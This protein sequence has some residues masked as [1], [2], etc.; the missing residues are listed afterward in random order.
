MRN[1]MIAAGCVLSLA[2]CAVAANPT[3]RLHP[4]DAD[5]LKAARIQVSCRI[6][7]AN[8]FPDNPHYAFEISAAVP[9]GFTSLDA[10]FW[11]GNDQGLLTNTAWS[12]ADGKC[13]ATFAVGEQALKGAWFEVQLYV[14][15]KLQTAGWAASGRYILRLAEFVGE[16]GAAPADEVDSVRREPDLRGFEMTAPIDSDGGGPALT[17]A[18]R[19][20][21]A[22]SNYLYDLRVAVAGRSDQQFEVRNG[23]PITKHDVRLADLNGD[24]DLDIL[25]VG[26]TGNRGAKEWFKT[27][28]YS[29]EQQQYRWL[30]E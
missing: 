12:S 5:R 13:V 20:K 21:E 4:D 17:I 6:L 16:Q 30:A 14:G 28:I 3:M 23:Q 25:I 9:E 22:F 7:N 26:G 1:E 18:V 29:G 8:V 24:G 10:L 19:R 27:L 15:D 11:L 2:A